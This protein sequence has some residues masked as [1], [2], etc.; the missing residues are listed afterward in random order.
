MQLP[1]DIKHRW[2]KYDQ[3]KV[4]EWDALLS[5][6]ELE[7][8]ASFQLERRRREF[9]L[10]RIGLRTLVAERTE[11]HPATVP[12][13]VAEDGCVE[14][15]DQDLHVSIAHADGVAVAA[16]AD[17]VMG[18]DIE[19]I[20]PRH[21]ELHRFILHP[22]EV[23]LFHQFP[24]GE[25]HTPILFWTLKE[26]TLKALR[27]GFRLSPKKLKLSIDLD[28]Q[29]AEVVVKNEQVLKLRFERRDQFYISVAYEDSP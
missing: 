4:A 19:R 15:V 5:A 7:R 26:A 1:P 24:L 6:E 28:N 11:S 2:M 29:I 25:V 8:R 21:P 27:T 18:V 22:D 12:L 9:T 23:A 16:I 10:G 17:R 20:A 3:T 14:V 13:T